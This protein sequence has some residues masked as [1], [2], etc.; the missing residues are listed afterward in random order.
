[1]I[2]KKTEKRPLDRRIEVETLLADRSIPI[3]IVVYTPEEMRALY[4]R[5]SPF[6]E[7]I[8]ENG[9]LVY[10][11]K[12]TAAWLREAEDEFESANLLLEHGKYKGACYHSLQ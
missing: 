9:R 6:V 3:D 10:M 1:M 4:S 5:G 11:R 12:A 7:E 8:V 2:V